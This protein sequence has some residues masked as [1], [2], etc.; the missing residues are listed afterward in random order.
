M[1]EILY[2]NNIALELQGKLKKAIEDAN[3]VGIVCLAVV[4]VG[5]DE[6]SDSYR[7]GINKKAESVGI[8]V[9]EYGY[10][11]SISEDELVYQIEKLGTDSEIN[12][13]IVQ[14]PLPKKYHTQRILD[15]I[16]LN[17]DL[18]GLSR[19]SI[20]NLYTKEKGFIPTTALAVMKMLDYYRIPLE[21][22]RAIIIGRSSAV[23]RPV[24]QLLL[25][26]NATVTV[27]HSK[28]QNLSS[29]TLDADIL[30]VA[31]GK[32]K[33]VKE[34]WVKDHTV[35][36]DV[37]INLDENNKICGDVDFQDFAQR[38]LMITPVPKGV[39]SLTSILLLSKVWE[40][41]QNG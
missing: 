20:A 39:G 11:E 10:E 29:L 1:A 21:G 26:R 36:I 7:R 22:K 41:Y 8:K 9:K 38:D 12:G 24:A 28:T 32:A 13:I 37:G 25:N 31:V 17:K 18:D 40:A 16:P 14:L 3:K 4:Y 23:G 19:L 6:G 27:A 35:I 5:N 34:S 33:L 2:G 30:V 15:A